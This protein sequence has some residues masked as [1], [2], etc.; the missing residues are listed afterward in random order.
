MTRNFV[1]IHFIR[2]GAILG[3]RGVQASLRLARVW[4]R[5]QAGIGS[6]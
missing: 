5:P 4:N 3:M 2:C 1:A 6:R